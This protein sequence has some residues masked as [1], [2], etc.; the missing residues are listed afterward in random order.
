M[1]GED[2]VRQ[3]EAVAH[4]V[5]PGGDDGAVCA[6][7]RSAVQAS[8]ARLLRDISMVDSPLRETAIVARVGL[9]LGCTITI[10][11]ITGLL[12]HL[13]L[14][15]VSYLPVPTRP[16]WLTRVTQG[17][18]IVAGVVLVPLTLVKLWLVYPKLFARPV[19]GSIRR[20]LERLSI[21]VLVGSLIFQISTGM[22]FISLRLVVFDFFAFDPMHYT[23][24]WV[25]VG[26]VCVHIAVKLDVITAAFGRAGRT[27]KRV[28]AAVGGRAR[29]EALTLAWVPLW[30]R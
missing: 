7:R 23:M 1:T 17:L 20:V 10:C 28:A 3:N 15:P 27:S 2:G 16:V 5:E 30:L 22:M 29:R 8:A 26:A 21:A 4:P 9:A 18:H 24:S 11:F 19:L 12:C 6:T 14:H 13:V 25:I